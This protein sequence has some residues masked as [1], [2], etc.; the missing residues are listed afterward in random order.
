MLINSA[1]RAYTPFGVKLADARSSSLYSGAV[2]QVDDAIGTRGGFL[3]NY[4]YEWGCTTGVVEG[5][6]GPALLCTL[7]WPFDGL[8]RPIIAAWQ[9]G[10]AGDY[11]NVA[12]PG[13]AEVLTGL[14]PD[15]FAAAINQPP[16]SLPSWGKAAGWAAA[17]VSVNRSSAMPPSHLLRLAFDTCH[18][19]A[20][21]VSLIRRAPICLPAIFTLVGLKLGEA[22]V[23]ERMQNDAFEPD[24][25]VAANHWASLPGPKGRARNPSS[26]RRRAAM[27]GLISKGGSISLDWLIPP[28]LQSETR[29]LSSPI[30]EAAA[31]W[32]KDGRKPGRRQQYSG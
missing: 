11:I 22:V 12:W 9:R 25:P 6:A 30:Q 18:G 29:W 24:Y 20:E 8:G 19:C 16:L 15:R 1:R 28:I 14:A 26:L 13:F 10:E 2:R 21:A 4:S 32:P 7:D 27:R 3:L 17:P 5:E 23:I 31:C